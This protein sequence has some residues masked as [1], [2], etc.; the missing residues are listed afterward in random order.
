MSM[1]ETH[2]TLV[3][4]PRIEDNFNWRITGFSAEGVCEA[5]ARKKL[6]DKYFDIVEVTDKFNRQS[7]SYQLNKKDLLH[8]WLKYKEGFSADLVN[9][10]LDEMNPPKEGIILDPFLGSGTTSMVCKMRGFNSIGIDV[11]PL[12]KLSIAAK[13][14]VFEYSLEELNTIISI[15]ENIKVPD[16]YSEKIKSIPITRSA[17][18]EK[19]ERE[20]AYYTEW[21]N[22]ATYTTPIKKLITLCLMN[23]LER[24]SYTSK[25]GQYLRWDYRAA[26]V[27]EAN[28]RRVSQGKKPVAATL[29]KG[30][31]PCVKNLLLQELRQKFQEIETIQAQSQERLCN[32]SINFIAGSALFELPKLPSHILSGVITSP[33]YCNRYD[34]TRT[35]ALELVYLG[36]SEM[37]IKR[38]RQDQLSCTVENKSKIDALREHYAAL[39]RSAH[40]ENILSVIHNNAVFKEIMKALTYRDQRREINNK[41]ILR[42]I[43]G[44]FTEL[45]F[46]YAELFRLCKP[47]AQV[48]FVNDNVRYG[49]EV[50]PVDFLSMELAESFGFKPK[51]IYTIRQQKGNSS[52]QMKK[53]GRLALRK[54]ITLWEKF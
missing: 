26:K 17:Y 28:A 33:P 24:L 34:Y 48:A 19:T 30:E 50:I 42:M 8:G 1:M 46:I 23:S 13:N 14:S 20:L 5:T 12:T 31:L 37:D 29:N 49:G 54:S 53:Y 32:T 15:L 36:L 11:L 3:S 39:G 43:S 9:L 45:T 52:Q 27:M 22:K 35:Y 16:N 10:L 18:P 47:G 51:K 40:F 41:G 44:Y 2:T 25:D 6:E 4:H 21:N 7:V 38:L